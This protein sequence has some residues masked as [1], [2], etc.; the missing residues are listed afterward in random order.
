MRCFFISLSLVIV[1]Q[2]LAIDPIVILIGPPGSGKGT[3]S[4][5]FRERYGYNHV[6][7]GDLL[8]S[9][10]A[11]QT[12]LGCRIAGTIQKGDYID[13]TIVRS[14]LAN[15][16]REYRSEGR[17]FVLDGFGR[18]PGD[19]MEIRSLIEKEGLSSRALVVCLEA[20]DAIC[21]ER[22]A[23]RSVCTN[24]GHVYHALWAQPRF[25]GRCDECDT[26]LQARMYDTPEVTKKRLQHHR[27][28][29]ESYYRELFSLF[30][31]IL[32]DA[33]GPLDECFHFYDSFAETAALCNADADQLTQKF[34][35][36]I[37]KR[38]C[39]LQ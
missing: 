30:P 11:K 15:K 7:I 10:V 26:P 29:I 23:K 19:A 21:L 24:C 14:L 20:P 6:S 35:N 12:E 38:G 36:Q 1:C 16:V 39:S 32:Y 8:R 4:Q 2:V 13:P 27:T 31:S 18:N 28:C 25:A 33:S 9:E 37:Q 34:S 3:F 17:P 5:Y 22:I